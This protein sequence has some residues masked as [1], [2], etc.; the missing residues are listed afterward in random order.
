MS[1]FSS[2]CCFKSQANV[3]DS[4][5]VG[6]ATNSSPPFVCTTDYKVSIVNGYSESKE[7]TLM[8][9][10]NLPTL[11]AI[12][13]KYDNKEITA[14]TAAEQII[15]WSFEDD[16]G[17]NHDSKWSY[18]GSRSDVLESTDPNV[19]MF[20]VE[21]SSTWDWKDIYSVA[22]SRA[23]ISFNSTERTILIDDYRYYV[24]G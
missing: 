15:E 20:K 24:A 17:S 23:V 16:F 11:C 19:E 21:C 8:N 1:L 3:G 4:G 22:S 5:G 13:T 7:P 12:V 9:L 6:K 14:L 10:S 2:L 18:N